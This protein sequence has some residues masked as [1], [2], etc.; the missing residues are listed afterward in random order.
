MKRSTHSNVRDG[1][2]LVWYADSLWRLAMPPAD[3]IHD[4]SQE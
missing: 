3:E 2:R 1:K 4:L